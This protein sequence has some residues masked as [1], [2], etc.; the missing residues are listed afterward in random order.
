M[1]A[2][3][4]FPMPAAAVTFALLHLEARAGGRI[5]LA[6]VLAVIRDKAAR[7]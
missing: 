3:Q 5:E 4:F 1:S 7:R 2:A 6:A